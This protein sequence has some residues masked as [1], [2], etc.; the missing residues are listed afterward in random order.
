MLP[1]ILFSGG[2]SIDGSWYTQTADSIDLDTYTEAAYESHMVTNKIGDDGRRIINTEELD[3]LYHMIGICQEKD[4]RA[5]M[6]TTP[7]LEEY[8]NM[9]EKKSPEFIGEFER[10]V[11][12]I[13]ENTGV[14]YYDYSHDSRFAHAYKLFLNADHLN[15]EGAVKFT[16]I[17]MSDVVNR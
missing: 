16:D 12:D 3:A 15:H 9:I 17:I 11:S 13:C 1:V 5:V 8:Y 4:A 6:V 7:F 2:S 10:M 14:E